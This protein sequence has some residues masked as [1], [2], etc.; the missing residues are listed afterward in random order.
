MSTTKV[1][2]GKEHNFQ[3]YILKSKATS[4]STYSNASIIKVTLTTIH[5]LYI[6]EKDPLSYGNK[7]N[8]VDSIMM[9]NQRSVVVNWV[10]NYVSGHQNSIH[11]STLHV[12]NLRA[13]RHHCLSDPYK[14]GITYGSYSGTCSHQRVHE[15]I[16]ISWSDL[17]LR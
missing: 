4:N 5:D 10:F 6:I 14:W 17:R 11:P 12:C 1:K 3:E 15:N 8:V 2:H 13:S 7:M 9:M 16:N